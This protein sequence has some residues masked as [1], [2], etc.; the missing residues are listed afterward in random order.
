[1]EVP[2]DQLQ[3]LLDAGEL[4]EIA[5]GDVLIDVGDQIVSTSFLLD[6]R[7]LLYFHQGNQL[8]EIKT[9][10]RAHIM[11]YL[12]F[13]R[14]VVSIIRVVCVVPGHLFVVP[15]DKILGATK[16]YYELTAALVHF[17]I[18][19]IRFAT[20]QQQQVEKMFALG[21][22]SAGLAHELNNPAAA[23]THNASA[24]AEL[25]ADVPKL[26]GQS[27]S[28]SLYGTQIAVVRGTLAGVL[29]R[30]QKSPLSMIQV[31]ENEAELESW[32]IS[33]GVD[34]FSIADTLL[35]AGFTIADLEIILNGLTATQAA[36]I[37]RWLNYHL[38]AERVSKEIEQASRRISALVGAVKNFSHM[39]RGNDKEWTDV[40]IG[41]ESTLSLLEHKIRKEAIVAVRQYAADLP[42][43]PV[44]PGQLNQVWVNLIDNAI[45][46]MSANGS[47]TLLITTGK[48]L[49]NVVVT[50]QDDGPGIPADILPKIFDP[51]FTTKGIGQGTGLG[52]EVVSAVIR[53]H[54]GT[55]NVDSVRGRTSFLVSLP[56]DNK[57]Q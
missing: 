35:A 12:P 56:I 10:E 7:C 17:M 15:A 27:A 11:G 33:H 29:G 42:Y 47:G 3:W 28:M 1:M 37:F 2:E 4:R 46:A 38:M 31:S 54:Q 39:D 18:S 20:T 26:F 55:I 5:E 6:G 8:N 49:N 52:L 24:L 45:D 22:L 50:I 41:I 30:D 19:R 36:T 32:M 57:G 53:Q 25:F 14:V 48:E 9:V 21:K 51:F 43:I 44:F 40:H 13:S 16:L 34:D 23:I